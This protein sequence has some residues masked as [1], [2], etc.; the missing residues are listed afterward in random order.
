MKSR[1]LPICDVAIGARS[2]TVCHLGNL[3]WWNN[4]VLKWDPENWRFVGDDEAN[5]WLDRPRRAPWKM[6]EI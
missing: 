3:A 5:S 6:L 1:K 4:R 2:V